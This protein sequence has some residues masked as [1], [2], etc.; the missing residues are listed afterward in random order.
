MAEELFTDSIN[1]LGKA[2]KKIKGDKPGKFFVEPYFNPDGSRK[3]VGG[4]GA[5][6]RAAFIEKNKDG[7]KGTVQYGND[8]TNKKFRLTSDG[9]NTT[10][11]VIFKFKDGGKVS[12]ALLKRIDNTKGVIYTPSKDQFKVRDFTRGVE[13]KAKIFKIK[14]YKTPALSECFTCHNR[15]D[16]PIPIGPKPQNINKDYLYIDGNKNQLTKW[17]E[18]GFLEPGYPLT[19]ESTVNWDNQSLPLDIRARSYVDINCAHCHT[20]GSYCQYRPIRFAFKDN[21]NLE[22]MGVCVP[23]ETDIGN[24]LTHIIKPN[25]PNESVLYFR[26]NSTIEQYR[27]PLLGRRLIHTEG[28]RLIEEWIDSL[29]TPC[30]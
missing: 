4:Y 2:V 8:D 20:E 3:I 26:I 19:I 14:D 15:Y 28:V 23:M 25:N 16:S 10:G 29:T 17:V 30:Q 24:G 18:Q 6:D 21:H 5:E 11:E 1:N 9:K 7:I 13:K 22:N 27:M 12:E